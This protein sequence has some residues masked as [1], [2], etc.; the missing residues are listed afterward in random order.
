MADSGKPIFPI[1]VAENR[2]QPAAGQ[3]IPRI[4]KEKFEKYQIRED[5][6]AEDKEEFLFNLPRVS[7]FHDGECIPPD[8]GIPLASPSCPSENHPASNSTQ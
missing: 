7:C 2:F 6:T 1:R 5:L 4:I 8:S 3:T